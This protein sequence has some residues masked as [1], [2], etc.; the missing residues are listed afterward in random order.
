MFLF[1]RV[2][3]PRYTFAQAH[4][5]APAVWPAE[6]TQRVLDL[7]DAWGAAFPSSH[8]AAAVVATL[9]ALRYWRRLGLVLT[10]LCVGLIAAVVYGQFHYA[11][12]A[13][14]GLIVAGAVLA[15]LRWGGPRGQFTARPPPPRPWGARASRAS[16]DPAAS[17]PA[18]RGRVGARAPPRAPRPRREA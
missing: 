16:P 11:V 7:G 12:D 4:T 1:F 8:V 2:A 17:R 5:A 6:L 9:C 3:G 13:L 10:P 15:S 14:A 18:A